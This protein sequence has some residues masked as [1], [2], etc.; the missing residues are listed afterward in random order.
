MAQ[1]FQ[2]NNEKLQAAPAPDGA[3]ASKLLRIRLFGSVYQALIVVVRLRWYAEVLPQL[4]IWTQLNRAFGDPGLRE[5]IRI[6]DR[7]FG[8][9]GPIARAP[10]TFDRSHF[11][12][13]RK[14]ADAIPA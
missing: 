2:Q 8:F 9:Q 6:G 1:G 14:T 12:C 7:H 4:G 13:V 3:G 10:I 5:D 11:V